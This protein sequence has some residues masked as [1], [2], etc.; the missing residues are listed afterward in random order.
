MGQDTSMKYVSDPPSATKLGLKAENGTKNALLELS[1]I[2]K[3]LD[4]LPKLPENPTNVIDKDKFK[5]F[6]N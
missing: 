4:P 5:T 3:R 2:L 6:L 1:D